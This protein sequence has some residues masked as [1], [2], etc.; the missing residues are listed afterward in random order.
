MV[1]WLT[2]WDQPVPPTVNDHAK[3][4]AEDGTGMDGSGG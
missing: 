3:R 2:A 4:H 1:D